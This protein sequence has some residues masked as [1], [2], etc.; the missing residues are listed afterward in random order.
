MDGIFPA[1]LEEGWKAVIPYLVIIFCAC[2]SSGYVPAI[3]QQVKVV[4]IPKPGRNS[5]FRST[6]YRHKSLPSFLLKTMERLVDMCLQEEALALMPLHPNQHAY[7]FWKLVETAFHQLAVWV[8]KV[9]EEQDTVLGV[10]L[11]IEGALNNSCYDTMCDVLVRHGSDYTIIW[12]IRANL[13]GSNPQRIFHEACDI[14]G[15]PAG[16]CAVPASMV[17]GGR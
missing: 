11:D 7:Q 16:R 17:P 3:R 13:K 15:L 4:F 9:L 12:W 10:F 8:E 14:Q 2:L 6:D 1:F 5:Y